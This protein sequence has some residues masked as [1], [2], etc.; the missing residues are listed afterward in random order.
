MP[1]NHIL[2]PIMTQVMF[3]R[4]IQEL[5]RKNKGVRN[6]KFWFPT[7]SWSS[8]VLTGV[9]LHLSE[10][11][12][13]TLQQVAFLIGS[14]KVAPGNLS[15]RAPWPEGLW[16]DCT[17]CPQLGVAPTQRQSLNTW[18]PETPFLMGHWPAYDGTSVLRTC[19]EDQKLRSAHFGLECRGVGGFW[20]ST[21]YLEKKKKCLHL[22][23]ANNTLKTTGVMVTAKG[24]D[25]SPDKIV[26]APN[27]CAPHFPHHWNE[28][29]Y[30]NKPGLGENCLT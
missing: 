23:K 2:L 28:D 25:S 22:L 7:W 9:S 18:N 17:F 29:K 26:S 19:P 10:P 8:W 11:R 16:S 12:F 6:L 24:F 14:P 5:I 3:W 27:C 30:T 4:W 21:F 15:L 1:H 20:H 13:L